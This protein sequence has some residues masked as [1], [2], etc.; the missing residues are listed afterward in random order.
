MCPYLLEHI[1]VLRL[2]KFSTIA[3]LLPTTCRDTRVLSRAF[4]ALGS[5]KLGSRV[6]VSVSKDH[7]YLRSLPPFYF[8]NAY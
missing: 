4:A 2:E 6:S 3:G 8:D 7:W 1:V 5:L